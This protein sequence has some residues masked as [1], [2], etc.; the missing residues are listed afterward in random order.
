MLRIKMGEGEMMVESWQCDS[1]DRK[2]LS[3][4]FANWLL[5]KGL[6]L[7]YEQ[8]HWGSS[9]FQMPQPVANFTAEMPIWINWHKLTLTVC[10]SIHSERCKWNEVLTTE[11]LSTSMWVF[12]QHESATQH[13]SRAHLDAIK[14]RSSC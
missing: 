12:P 8:W 5:P 14:N 2:I 10:G 7:C 1:D 11:N 6:L 13:F 9:D 4:D 3:S